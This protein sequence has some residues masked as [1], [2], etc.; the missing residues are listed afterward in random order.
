VDGVFAQFSTMA[1]IYYRRLRLQTLFAYGGKCACCGESYEPFLT[2]DHINGDGKADHKNST[3][4]YRR[5]RNEGWPT[6]Y[7]VLCCNC[8]WRKGTGTACDCQTATRI[9]IEEQLDS[10]PII[11][12]NGHDK[13]GRKIGQ[14]VS[15]TCAVCG[16]EY[17]L[18]QWTAK[19]SQ[20]G[21]GPF[22]SLKC[23]GGRPRV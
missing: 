14:P 8:N 15:V 21:S 22:C 5:L 16:K 1:A 20:D 18:D 13:Y 3:M 6:G 4:F 11:G 2:M 10:I 9:D 7:Q 12:K 19:R 23:F 17:F